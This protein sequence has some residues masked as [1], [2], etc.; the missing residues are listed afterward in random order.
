MDFRPLWDAVTRFDPAPPRTRDIR[1]SF[2]FPPSSVPFGFPRG[3]RHKADGKREWRHFFSDG[4][5][6]A[7]RK[8]NETKLAHARSFARSFR[9]LFSSPS[10]RSIGYSLLRC[11]GPRKPPSLPF[12]LLPLFPPCYS[13]SITTVPAPDLPMEARSRDKLGQ[14]IGIKSGRIG[15]S[16]P[17]FSPPPL[18]PPHLF[19]KRVEK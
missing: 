19:P 12:S 7:P 15:T 8:R 16:R 1:F 17:R 18:S 11:G 3:R 9:R 4:V 13:S 10:S 5:S 6:L 14:P 2:F